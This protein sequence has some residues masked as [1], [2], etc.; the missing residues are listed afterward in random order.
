MAYISLPYLGEFCF[1]DTFLRKMFWGV[2]KCAGKK[3]REGENGSGIMNI[4][5]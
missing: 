4:E 2:S 5:H 3:R 1:I